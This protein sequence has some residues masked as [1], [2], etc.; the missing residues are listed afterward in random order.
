MI[1]S[2]FV[3]KTFAWGG[4]A[5]NA[6]PTTQEARQPDIHVYSY[7][8]LLFPDNPVMLSDI[9]IKVMMQSEKSVFSCV[10][11]HFLDHTWP[12]FVGFPAIQV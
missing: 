9:K 6:H 7:D 8:K 10:D 3:E 2:S 5:P 1:N 11:V 4:G 12:A